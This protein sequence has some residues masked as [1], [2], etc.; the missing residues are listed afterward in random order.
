LV[1]LLERLSLAYRHKRT[2]H[3]ILDNY[4][5][6]GGRRVRAWVAA[7]RRRPEVRLHFLP[8]YC[9]DDNRIERCVWRELH[10]NVT[11]N[12]RH[13][14]IESLMHAVE[15]WLDARDSDRSELR[16]AI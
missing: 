7:R 3:V 6:H 8:P 10:R 15:R 12:H 14:T 16:Q 13:R 5:V 4:A 9:P 1:G 2:V 11:V